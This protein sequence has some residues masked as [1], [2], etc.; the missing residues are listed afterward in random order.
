MKKC[1]ICQKPLKWIKFKSLDGHVCKKC[2]EIVS[3]S[4]SQTITQKTRDELIEIYGQ[5]TTYDDSK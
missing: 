5:R 2:Y 4:F 3:V 1:L